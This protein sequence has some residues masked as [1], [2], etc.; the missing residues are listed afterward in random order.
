[1]PS[2]TP[3]PAPS[4]TPAPPAVTRQLLAIPGSLRQG[5]FSTAVALSLP[6]LVTT[7]QTVDQAPPLHDIPLYN[8]DVFDAGLP[9]AVQALGEAV[10]RADGL[11]FVTPEY[12]YSVPGVLKNAIDWLSR[13]KNKPLAGKPVALMSTSPGILGGARAQYHLRQVLVAV[14]ARVMNLPEVMVGQVDRKVGGTP[15]RL[16]DPDARAHI[17]KQLQALDQFMT[18]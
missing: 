2:L 4:D 18:G 1:M 14:D 11:V 12:N 15:L 6:D 8:Q 3:S 10:A 5:A 7:G 16:T 13:L 17:Q 9:A